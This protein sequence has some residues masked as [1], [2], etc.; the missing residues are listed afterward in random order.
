[1]PWCPECRMEYRDGLDTCTECGEAIAQE[2]ARPMQ[3]GP[4]PA[5]LS[6]VYGLAAGLSL[7]V[8]PII[9]SV[10][11]A[12]RSSYGYWWFGVAVLASGVSGLIFGVALERPHKRLP[13]LI[14]WLVA[15]S[16]VVAGLAFVL[17]GYPEPIDRIW[18]VTDDLIWWSWLTCLVSAGPI[19]IVLGLGVRETAVRRRILLFLMLLCGL[20]LYYKIAFDA[21]WTRPHH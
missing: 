16:P 5:W 6:G 4:A 9:V 20:V 12:F 15:Y 14:G 13:L 18:G 17:T 1:M 2:P 7:T 19:G 11:Y 10:P 8:V 21:L 3:R